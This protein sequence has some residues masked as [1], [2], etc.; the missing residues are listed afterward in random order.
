[1]L[2]EIWVGLSD[3]DKLLA[4]GLAVGLGYVFARELGHYIQDYK[5]RDTKDKT[6]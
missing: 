1:M 5:F 2:N 6:K 3:D 4:I